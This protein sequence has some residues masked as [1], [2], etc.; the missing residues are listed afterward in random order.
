MRFAAYLFAV[1]ATTT[2]LH[3]APLPSDCKQ[4]IVGLADSWD[5]GVGRIQCFERDGKTWRAVS[6]P[7]RVLFG[8]NGLAWGVGL[9]GQAEAGKRKV[10][11]D[12]RAPA[13]LF[14]LGKIYTYDKALPSG[15]D[16][17]FHTVTAA[18]CWIS[19]PALPQYN[20]YVRVD[21]ANPPP[22]F[23]K[24]QMKQDDFAHAWKIEIRH[25]DSPPQPGAGSAIFFHIQRGPNKHSSGCT[26]MPEPAILSIVKWLRAG[27]DPHYVL[28]P[29]EEYRAK[30]KVWALPPPPLVGIGE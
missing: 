19:N 8:T 6:A 16:Y 11:G 28:L 20:Q 15:A 29:V 14:S 26:T 17:P 4:L 7:Q 5:S 23:K 9:A 18:D 27:D 1:L 30:W 22:W 10:E 3:A 13:G 21:P 24:E 12:K 2:A 25:N